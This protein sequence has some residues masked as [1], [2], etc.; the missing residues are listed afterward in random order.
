M[1]QRCL[2]L[3]RARHYSPEWL[4]QSDPS[5]CA[6]SS[7]EIINASSSL[8]KPENVARAC[9]KGS[10]SETSGSVAD[11]VPCRLRCTI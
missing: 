2:D 6:I 8:W 9:L 10:R 7:A 3:R 5:C 4:L 11:P 1:G